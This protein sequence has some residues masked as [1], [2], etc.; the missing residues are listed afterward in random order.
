MSKILVTEIKREVVVTSED[1]ANVIEVQSQRPIIEVASHGLQGPTGT[2]SGGPGQ[3]WAIGTPTES[4]NGSRT[5]FT[6]P[7]Y[8]S[9]SLTVYLNG[10]RESH[11]TATSSTSITFA[12]APLSGDEISL[13]YRAP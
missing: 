7:S 9:G 11:F 3:Q 4:P 2:G 12:D 13:F 6:V 8:A 5:T 1:T 10:L